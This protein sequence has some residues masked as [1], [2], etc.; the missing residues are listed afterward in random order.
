MTEPRTAAGPRTLAAQGLHAY[1]ILGTT[2]V[3]PL[4]QSE[5]L[6]EQLLAIEAEAASPDSEALRAALTFADVR[7]AITD[8]YYD[9]RNEGGTMEKAADLAA[10]RVMNL[11]S[12]ARS[13]LTQETKDD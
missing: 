8:S 12:Q 1:L 2:A 6:V 7:K 5:W 4:E 13:A 10:T 3:L 11:Q 9:T